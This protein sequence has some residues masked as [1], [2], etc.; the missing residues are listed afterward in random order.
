MTMVP[1]Y[2]LD[3]PAAGIAGVKFRNDFVKWDDIRS[4]AIKGDRL[5]LRRKGIV[6]S[7]WVP[8]MP[9]QYQRFRNQVLE[10]APLESEV[11]T[12]LKDRMDCPVQPQIV[13]V[14]F[15]LILLIAAGV[16]IVAW[17]YK[18]KLKEHLEEQVSPLY[19]HKV[20]NPR[21]GAAQ[22]GQL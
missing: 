22:Y 4:V 18:D 15:A 21:R 2:L 3:M 19:A 14:I 13:K 10:F 12:L 6:V 20:D 8:L 9:S 11:R 5:V 7:M 17:A 16:F 1:K